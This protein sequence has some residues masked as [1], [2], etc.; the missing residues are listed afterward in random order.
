M[1]HEQR[2]YAVCR[3]IIVGLMA[4]LFT[5]LPAQAHASQTSEVDGHSAYASLTNGAGAIEFIELEPLNTQS[6]VNFEHNSE[7]EE[8]Y[9]VDLYE[10]AGSST[11]TT[12]KSASDGSLAVTAYLTVRYQE[13]DD[14]SV[15]LNAVYGRWTNSDRNVHITSATLRYGCVGFGYA[16]SQYRELS[17]ANNF[18]YNTGFTQ[19]VNSGACTMGANLTLG[20][21]HGPNGSTWTLAIVNNPYNSL[22][23]H[24]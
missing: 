16:S 17:V 19:W 22:P 3:I 10:R 9:R 20:L 7:F 23:G 4:L 2:H 14:G 15:L 18:N 24:A 13:T 8:S 11:L 5:I 1:K 12:E 6:T 21:R